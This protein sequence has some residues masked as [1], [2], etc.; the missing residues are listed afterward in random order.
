MLNLALSRTIT[1]LMS[2]AY[3]STLRAREL[4]DLNGCAWQTCFRAETCH[5]QE[6]FLYFRVARPPATAAC[7]RRDYDPSAG[8]RR[9]K[10]CMS[11][12]FHRLKST[13]RATPRLAVMRWAF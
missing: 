12:A 2:Q 11:V 7:R 13:K 10:Q 1:Q 4:V 6:N 3:S 8:S 9:Q 5:R